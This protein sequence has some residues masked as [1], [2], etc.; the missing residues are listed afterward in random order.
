MTDEEIIN[1]LRDQ[2]AYWRQRIEEISKKLESAK[3][4]LARCERVLEAMEEL[5]VKQRIYE[6]RKGQ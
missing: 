3:R 5:Q 6:E 2:K 1:E 4:E